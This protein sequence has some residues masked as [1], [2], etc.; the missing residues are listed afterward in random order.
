LK[1]GLV[2]AIQRR[3][4]SS[5]AAS[6]LGVPSVEPRSHWAAVSWPRKTADVGE[7]LGEGEEELLELGGLELRGEPADGFGEDVGVELLAV[8]GDEGVGELVDEAHG[9]EG[10]GV[11]GGGG[12]GVGAGFIECSGEAARGGDI[13]EDDVAVVG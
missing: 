7:L 2:L 5:R 11:E 6:R 9:E 1:A 13:G 12:I 4:S 3:R 8:A 10:A